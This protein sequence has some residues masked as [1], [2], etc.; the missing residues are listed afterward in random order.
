[1]LSQGLRPVQIPNMIM[2][3]PQSSKQMPWNIQKNMFKQQRIFWQRLFKSVSTN[4]PHYLQWQRPLFPSSFNK[5]IIKLTCVSKPPR[6]LTNIYKSSNK[7]KTTMNDKQIHQHSTI[8]RRLEKMRGQ[9]K[10][11][12]VNKCF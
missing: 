3:M 1:M 8:C 6:P 11:D 10:K 7:H 9:I 2:I 12:F 4:D 5:T